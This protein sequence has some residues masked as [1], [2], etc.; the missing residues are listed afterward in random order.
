MRIDMNRF[1]DSVA[2]LYDCLNKGIEATG[3]G[4]CFGRRVVVNGVAGPYSWQ[5]YNEVKVLR[6]NVG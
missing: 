5:S 2:T 1:D 4:A 6:D 3:D